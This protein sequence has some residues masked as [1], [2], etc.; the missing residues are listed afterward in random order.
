LGQ[1]ATITGP[2][3]IRAGLELRITRGLG[4]G[5]VATPPCA[6]CRRAPELRR[7]DDIR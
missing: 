1:P 7:S 6:H 5:D 3:D 2:P 4:I